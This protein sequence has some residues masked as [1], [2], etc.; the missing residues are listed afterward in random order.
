MKDKWIFAPLLF[1][2]VV[3]FYRADL[4]ES[5]VRRGLVILTLGAILWSFY[6]V[7]KEPKLVVK[8]IMTAIIIGV[9]S[10]L[11]IILTLINTGW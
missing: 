8:K 6:R 3:S 2:I 9:L 10:F 4:F 5:F 11:L 7:L 1:S